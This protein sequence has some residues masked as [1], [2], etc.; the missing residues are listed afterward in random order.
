VC[1]L[2]VLSEQL[3]TAQHWWRQLFR[4][5]VLERWRGQQPCRFWL[6]GKQQGCSEVSTW[7]SCEVQ[8]TW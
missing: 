7:C 3:K 8:Q 5:T 2:G 6:L 1:G 4:H